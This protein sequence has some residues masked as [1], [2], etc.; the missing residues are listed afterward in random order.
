MAFQ[1][2]SQVNAALGRT[3]F[4]PFLAGAMQGAQAQARGAENIAQGLA[5]FGKEVAKGMASD[6]EQKKMEKTMLGTIASAEKLAP[7]LAGLMAMKDEKGNSLLDPRISKSLEEINSIISNKEGRSVEE[8]YAASQTFL[9]QAPTVMNAGLKFYDLQSGIEQKKAIAAQKT[10]DSKAIGLAAAPYLPGNA[11]AGIA[12]P[13][14]K[15]DPGQFLA[16]YTNAGGSTE[17]LQKSDQ[18]IKMLGVKDGEKLT[19]AMKNTQSIVAAEIKAGKLDSADQKSIDIRTAELIAQGGADRKSQD[20][21]PG[22]AMVDGKNQYVGTSVFNQKTGKFQLFSP[23]TGTFSDIPKDARPSTV[24]QLNNTQLP[25]TQFLALRDKV[26]ADEIS[27]DKLGRYMNS[28]EGSKYGLE[29]IAD[30]FSSDM[31]TLFSSGNLTPSQLAAAKSQGE[32]QAL[33]G[34]NRLDILGGG[35]MTE[36][37]AVRVILYFGGDANALRNPEKVRQAIASIYNDRY[38]MYKND[39]ESYNIQQGNYYRHYQPASAIEFNEK[40]LPAVAPTFDR[41]AAVRRK[42]E[43]EAIAN[44]VPSP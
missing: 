19:T 37:D 20:Y 23:A 35:V 10:T 34:S 21:Q 32:L 36:Q 18:I 15:F 11:P 24:S 38:K 40:F 17:G 9:T 33:I 5:G 8:R 44:A 7:A 27:L 22:S 6:V 13:A 28:V 25:P 1:S 39:L 4:T 29:L 31:K 14:A 41:E 2:G 16:D 12:R 30:R 26:H 43:L 42:A 3:D